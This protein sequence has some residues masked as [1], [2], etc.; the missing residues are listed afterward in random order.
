MGI[1]LRVCH[2]IIRD[3]RT[4][5]ESRSAN[6]MPLAVKAAIRHALETEGGMPDEDA[7]EY[8]KKM[9][10]EGRLFEECWS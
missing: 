3:S 8:V 7:R 10:L 1:Y 2:L 9:E 4:H 6:K 5:L